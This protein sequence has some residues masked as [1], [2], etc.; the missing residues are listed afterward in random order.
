[1]PAAY[2]LGRA[3]TAPTHAQPYVRQR[4]D[5]QT[6]TLSVYTQ[7]PATSVFDAA[8]ASIEVPYEPLAPGPSGSL[9]VVHDYDEA[10]DR[11]YPPVDLDSLGLA[12]RR[13]LSPSTT[14]PKYAQQMVYALAS[15]TYDRFARALGRN[16]AFGFDAQPWEEHPHLKLRPHA[17]QEENAWYDPEAREVVFGYFRAG[18]KARWK[19][20]PGD[21][22]FTSLSHDV[23]VHE[24]S[25]ALLDGMRAHFLLPTNLDVSALHEGFADLVAVFQRFTHRDLVRHAIGREKGALTSTLLTDMAR[26]FGQTGVDGDGRTA[27]RT[28]ILDAG[29]ADDDVP[30][31][32][33]YERNKEEHDRGAVLVT[34]VFEAF[35]RVYDRKTEKLRR[36]AGANSMNEALVDLLAEQ[37]AK[38]AGQFL[39]IVIRAI[40]YCPPV[41]ITFGEFLRAM[42]T[43]DADVVP[44]DP[45]G[46]REALVL[47]FRRY[48]ITVHS[49]PDLSEEALLWRAPEGKTLMVKGLAWDQMQHTRIPGADPG[50]PQRI[51]RAQ[52]VGDV[53][54]NP[55]VANCFGLSAA[56][57]PS[58]GLELPVIQSVRT[59][60]R[61]SP[62]GDLLFN[63][64]VEVTQR[65]RVKLAD[66]S[67]YWFHGGS[68]V[69]LDADGSIRYSIAKNVDSK[70][71]LARFADYIKRADGDTKA[72]LRMEAPSRSALFRRLHAR[73]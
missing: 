14:E 21:I 31:K 13:G 58:P 47:A 28:A 57:K 32:F 62:D 70:T 15:S 4:D 36:I 18:R 23:V 42:I 11:M 27:L 52:A 3:V 40:D 59:L 54:T 29:G 1:M 17:M 56:G 63:T 39:S 73:S 64:I 33:R 50:A 8:I 19:T 45:L 71:R 34:A 26:Q 12:L 48:G 38:L 61:V 68:T 67:R 37:A 49:V 72:V 69:V 60:R 65:R 35:R 30:A 53:V 44:G 55:A 2:T 16:P 10:L 20:Q 51:A 41:D 9:F 7:D 24:L 46:Y 6:R 5:P 25:H 66:G 22:V 43:A